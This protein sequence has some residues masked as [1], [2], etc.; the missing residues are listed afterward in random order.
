MT[1][2]LELA[3]EL[4]SKEVAVRGH[5]IKVRA[6]KLS[7][8]AALTRLFPH[9]LPPITLRDTT[10]GSAAPLLP[11]RNDPKYLS[12]SDTWTRRRWVLEI[13]LATEAV[14]L[15][16]DDDAG[17]T[18]ELTTVAEALSDRFTEA[19]VV[20]LWSTIHDLL[21]ESAQ[22]RARDGL[23]VDVSNLEADQLAKVETPPEEY[24]TTLGYLHFRICERYGYPMEYVSEMDGGLRLQYE[25]Q[26]KFRQWEESKR[27]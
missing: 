3:L 23:R 9:P 16:K 2:I 12:D 17:N 15:R 11:D 26:E 6:L 14:K 10:K 5:Q 22:Q 19:E 1:S 7:E 25:E 21:D 13:A 8:T 24:G 18:S 4:N 27:V 20:R